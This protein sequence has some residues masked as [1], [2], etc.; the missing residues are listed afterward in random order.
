[1]KRILLFLVAIAI[2]FNLS[3]EINLGDIVTLP[4]NQELKSKDGQTIKLLETVQITDNAGL[5]A[6]GPHDVTVTLEA[7]A[8]YGVSIGNIILQPGDSKVLTINLSRTGSRIILPIYP[9]VSGVEG[10]APISLSIPNI[11][12]TACREG[13]TEAENDCFTLDVQVLNASCIGDHVYQVGTGNCLLKGEQVASLSCP[14]DYTKTPNEFYCEKTDVLEAAQG[15]DDGFTLGSSDCK[16]TNVSLIED[17]PQTHYLYDGTCRSVE[18]KATGCPAGF[19]ETGGDC[20][21][22]ENESP[23][24]SCPRGGRLSGTNCR[25]YSYYSVPSWSCPSGYRNVGGGCYAKVSMLPDGNSCRTGYTFGK[26]SEN[27]CVESA[28]YIYG[29]SKDGGACSDGSDPSWDGKHYICT[30][31]T[32]YSHTPD[33]YCPESVIG[34]RCVNA[35]DQQSQI[36]ECGTDSYDYGSGQCERD[37]SYYANTNC[38]NGYSLNNGGECE[39]ITT[40]E[41]LFGCASGFTERFDGQCF[42]LAVINDIGSCPI[43]T[44][45]VGTQCEAY[46]FLPINYTCAENWSLTGTICEKYDKQDMIGQC[47]PYYLYRSGTDKCAASDVQPAALDCPAGYEVNVLAN[48]CEKIVREPFVE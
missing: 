47:N 4:V 23:S 38:G 31:K 43:G 26:W 14:L 34:G 1:M 35:N 7:V 10:S 20:V 16:R 22:T 24:Y 19:F 21:K 28:A 48:Q 8:D 40:T 37:D 27:L 13:F 42:S 12:I 17:C 33:Y 9:L 44:V 30:F 18:P 6:R 36:A 5:P 32:P 41:Y 29:A 45:L 39:R 2:C 25:D 11:K 15:C 46:D 3:A